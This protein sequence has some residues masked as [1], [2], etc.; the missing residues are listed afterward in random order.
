[1]KESR[2][3]MASLAQ[4]LLTLLLVQPADALSMYLG[5]TKTPQVPSSKVMDTTS[6]GSLTVPKVGVGTISWSSD[7]RK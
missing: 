5:G 3:R 4:A 2:V 6:L 7:S 1:M